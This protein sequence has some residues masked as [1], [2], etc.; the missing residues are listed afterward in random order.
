[1]AA[2]HER[3]AQDQVRA[4]YER[5][6]LLRVEETQTPKSKLAEL[7]ENWKDP[8]LPALQ[9]T[10]A[11]VQL[12][13]LRQGIVDP[14]F[15]SFA[16]ALREI[17]LPVFS[18]LDAACASGYYSEVLRILDPRPI[19]YTGCD[20]S[21]AMIDAARAH[22]PDLT[23]QV[24]DLTQL[25]FGDG[26]FDVVLA[27]GVL[28]HISD[29]EAAILEACRVAR[30]AV[31]LHRCPTTSAR[32]NEHTVGA[33]YNIR[34]ART[35]FAKDSLIAAFGKAGFRLRADLPLYPTGTSRPQRWIGG[36]ARSLG[37][38]NDPH[39]RRQVTLVLTRA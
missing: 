33:Q 4:T 29:Y 22:Y 27:S 39:E 31:I 11:D 35:F 26:A 12:A 10:V 5:A 3:L 9:R 16:R 7:S 13:H 15:R 34:T 17:D 18:L 36:L 37:L 28:E 24:E 1:M 20:Y 32:V 19:S 38:R 30:T 25:S 8:Q 14:V 2:D 21:P 23:F 6:Q